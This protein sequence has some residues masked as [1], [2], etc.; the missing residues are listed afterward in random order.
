MTS[1]RRE[2]VLQVRLRVEQ[3]IFVARRLGREVARAVGLERQDQTRFATALSEIGRVLLAGGGAADVAFMP[4]PGSPPTLWVEMVSP[5]APRAA[6]A[7]DTMPVRRLVDTMEVAD[8]EAG[9][10]VRMSRRLPAQA[11]PLTSARLDEIRAE[12]AA[13]SPG[14]PLE[15]LADQNEQLI[16]ALDE[17][18]A[19]RDEL[20][21]LNAELEDTNSGVMALYHQLSDELE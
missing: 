16:A 6:V 2:P 9:T 18:R 7:D 10:V 14:S 15:E 17:V 19:Q 1:P 13:L 11:P 8:A 21:R 20:A 3:D 5:A 4:T 12:L